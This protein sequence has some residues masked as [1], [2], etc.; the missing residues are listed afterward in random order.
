MR[1]REIVCYLLIVV[2]PLSAGDDKFAKAIAGMFSQIAGQPISEK[3]LEKIAYIHD[4]SPQSPERDVPPIATY[5]NPKVATT[6]GEVEGTTNEQAHA[7]YQIP[8]AEPPIGELRFQ[9]PEALKNPQNINGR[10]NRGL[11]C[12]QPELGAGLQMD[13][14]C[15]VLNVY[16]PLNVSLTVNATTPSQRLPVLVYIHGGSFTHGQS[17]SSSLEGSELAAV[18]NMV[19]VT[20]NYRLGALGF[21]VHKEGGYS[22]I[23]G[24]QGLKDQQLALQWV[25]DNIK[26]FGGDETLV[27]ISGTSAGAQSVMFHTLSS[28]SEPLYHKAIQQ[29]NP[30]VFYYQT[31]DES[32]E[33]TN[34]LLAALRCNET[35]TERDCL[36]TVSTRA[37]SS[38]Q[39]SVM[40]RSFVNRDVMGLIEPFRPIID[41]VEFSDQPLHLYR[42]SKWNSD[43]DMIVGVETEEM[44]SIQYTLPPGP[45]YNEFLFGVANYYIFGPGTT[46]KVV[47]KYEADYA[48]GANEDWAV[49]FSKEMTHLYF[50][51][52]S[53]ALARYA[54]ATATQSAQVYFYANEHPVLDS[55][56]VSRNNSEDDCYFATH[57]SDIRFLFRTKSNPTEDDLIVEDEF[58]TYWGSF[59]RTGSPSNNLETPL[60]DF[61][62]WPIYTDEVAT[63]YSAIAKSKINFEIYAKLLPLM[64]RSTELDTGEFLPKNTWEN[65]LI[66]APNSEIMDDFEEDICDFWDS[67]GYYMDPIPL[68]PTTT[69]ATTAKTETTTAANIEPTTS[70][71]AICKNSRHIIGALSLLMLS[72]NLRA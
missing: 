36:M 46:D 6:S 16:S 3:D 58:S 65:I 40:L 35:L 5:A 11:R 43:K 38:R 42:D 22:D 41:G 13:E 10:V 23:K 60:G 33:I 2:I 7:F 32:L 30:A 44:E 14:D 27:T 21:L 70:R 62:G 26:N 34:Y 20:I 28:I 9:P 19:V 56:C 12:P 31:P 37:L 4:E 72:K 54:S 48:P 61:T 39:I 1:T 50:I 17:T 63:D 24:N 71:A 15:L 57:G 59:A 53:R 25:Q 55:T 52:P 64:Y 69:A 8:Y 68:P 45:E 29:S 49:T 66:K 51:C 47:Q 18:T 67:V